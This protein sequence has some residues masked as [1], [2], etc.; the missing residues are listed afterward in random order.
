LFFTDSSGYEG[1]VG[2]SAV[3]LRKGIFER[4]YLRTT[5]ESIVYVAELNSIEIAVAKFVN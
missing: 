1:I 5:D 4:R 3:A 2:A